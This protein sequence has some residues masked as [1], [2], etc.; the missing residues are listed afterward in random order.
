MSESKFEMALSEFMCAEG[1][2]LMIENEV[3]EHEFSLSFEKKMEKLI[4]RRRKPYF[5]MINT[6]GKRVACIAACAFIVSSASLMSVD[7]VRE[8]VFGFIMNIFEDHS[9][10][11]TFDDDKHPD[12]I[13]DIYEITY[14][15][16]GYIVDFKDYHEDHRITCYI[17][18]DTN[19]QIDFYQFTSSAF[20]MRINTEEAEIN[21]IN[22]DEQDMIYYFDNLGFHNLIWDNGEYI[23]M[24]SS[25]S[26]KEEIIEMMKSI[27]KVE[28]K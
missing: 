8:A 10:I 20:N 28:T 24:I 6:V 27:K 23:F 11:K 4:N 2:E 13:E 1:E 21:H 5:R 7:A 17:K 16:S 19:N 22:I 15:L 12:I 25:N 18:A 3:I 9:D 14:D 26:T